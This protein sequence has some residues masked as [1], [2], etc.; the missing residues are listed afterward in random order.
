[1]ELIPWEDPDPILGAGKAPGEEER[2]RHGD[3]FGRAV[4]REFFR[5]FSHMSYLQFVPVL[6]QENNNSKAVIT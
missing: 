6:G 3:V 4:R 1:M 5:A 2:D